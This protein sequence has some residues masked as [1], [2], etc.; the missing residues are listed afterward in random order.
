M[1]IIIYFI[2]YLHSYVLSYKSTI[3]YYLC[4]FIPQNDQHGKQNE[5]GYALIMAFHLSSLLPQKSKWQE[6]DTHTL[7]AYRNLLQAYLILIND[8]PRNKVYVNHHKSHKK[9]LL[10]SKSVKWKSVIY[11]LLTIAYSFIAAYLQLPSLFTVSLLMR[12]FNVGSKLFIDLL[13]QQCL[14]LSVITHYTRHNDLN[15]YYCCII[16]E[17]RG[18]STNIVRQKSSTCT[19]QSAAD[20]NH[21]FKVLTRT[22]ANH[23]RIVTNEQ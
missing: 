17:V 8:R 19:L 12:Y 23:E 21:N 13:C 16:V 2:T 11:A 14:S 22:H 18:F 15:Y 5:L 1:V 7:I 4:N 3:A 10:S 6:W 20:F 9:I